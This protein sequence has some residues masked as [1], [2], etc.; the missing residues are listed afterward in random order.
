MP[1]IG[2]STAPNGD[3]LV[4]RRFVIHRRENILNLPPSQK[5]LKNNPCRSPL[6]TRG[7]KSNKKHREKEA[8]IGISWALNKPWIT[9]YIVMG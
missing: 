3:P 9:S 2:V 1:P 8:E 4:V 5:Y 7:R 6:L